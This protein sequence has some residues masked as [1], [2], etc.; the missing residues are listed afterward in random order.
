[1]QTSLPP[2]SV[3]SAPVPLPKPNQLAV[4]YI[5]SQGIF[6][7]V[8]VLL[9]LPATFFFCLVY[10]SGNIPNIL[11]CGWHFVLYLLLLDPR[12]HVQFRCFESVA[13]ETFFF[14]SFKDSFTY[15]KGSVRWEVEQ[16]WGKESFHQLLYFPK[17]SD[18]WDWATPKP[19]ARSFFSSPLRVQQSKHLGALYCSLQHTSRELELKRSYQNSKWCPYTQ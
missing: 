9:C 5:T 1:M 6:S 13:P 18:T 15:L 2:L 17:G 11:F 16:R 7:S 8:S 10:I 4:A 14:F 19:G 3:L 12:D